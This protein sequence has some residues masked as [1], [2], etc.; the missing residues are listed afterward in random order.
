MLAS[1]VAKGAAEAAWE[2][3]P[4][5]RFLKLSKNGLGTTGK[6][7]AK[8]VLKQMGQEGLEEFG[9]EITND[10]TDTLIKGRES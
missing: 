3:A 1:G 9:T 5:M 8:N 4:T 2:Y 10:L 7:V 6:E